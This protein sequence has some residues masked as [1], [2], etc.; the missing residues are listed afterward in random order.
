[1]VAKN[2]VCFN[3]IVVRNRVGFM[4]YNLVSLKVNQKLAGLHC[5]ETHSNED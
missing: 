4:D 2:L 5:A 3:V 1:M